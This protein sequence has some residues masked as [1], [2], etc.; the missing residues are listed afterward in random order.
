MVIVDSSVW[1][2]YINRNDTV[3]TG[4]LQGLLGFEQL[5]IG[6]IILTEVLQ[7][8]RSDR[9]Y[10]RT[11]RGLSAFHAFEML[12][13]ENAILSAENYRWLRKR[14]ITIRRT[15]DVMIATFCIE[16]GHQLLFSDVDFEPFVEHL[17]L[18]AVR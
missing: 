13:A 2:D 7:G 4:I 16:E 5:G 11:R 17:G 6:D 8:F 10:R 9:D 1:I 18:V 15:T 3:Q 14:G 12:G